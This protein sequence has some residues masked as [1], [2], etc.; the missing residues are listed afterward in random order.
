MT[1]ELYEIKDLLN[2]LNIEVMES[3]MISDGDIDYFIF[4]SSNLEEEQK[5]RLRSLDFDEIRDNLFLS[6]TIIYNPNEILEV[7]KPLF[8]QSEKN[9][10]KIV[11][12]KIY[13][14]NKMY[15]ARNKSCLF[16][17]RHEH[18]IMP[19]EWNGKLTTNNIELQAFI[20]ILNKLIRQ[21]CKE[22][23]EYMEK[24]KEHIF[25]KIIA[26]L[27]NINAHIPKNG[28]KEAVKQAERQKR[29]YEVLIN[30]EA[31]DSNFPVDFINTQ[32]KLLEYCD[33]F[34]EDIIG[35]L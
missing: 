15:L 28:I 14:V 26:D 33:D 1:D 17:L 32:I 7:L 34:L 10:W 6:D 20:N 19:L 25:W 27:R 18:F 5:E 22:E 4:S 11:I 3:K 29:A 23:I 2:D 8:L 24:F 21:S 16:D 12:N 35:D 13:R 31:P 30:K 9:L